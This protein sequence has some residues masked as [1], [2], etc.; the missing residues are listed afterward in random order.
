MKWLFRHSD[1]DCCC[2][3]MVRWR[4]RSVSQRLCVSLVTLVW[5]LER[6]GICSNWRFLWR[7]AWKVIVTAYLC[8]A[9]SHQM[10]RLTRWRR[11]RDGRPVEKWPRCNAGL[12]SS[13]CRGC[14]WNPNMN[15]TFRCAAVSG[16]LGQSAACYFWMWLTDDNGGWIIAPLVWCHALV[17]C[18]APRICWGKKGGSKVN[19]L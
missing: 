10:L 3:N 14:V 17:W 11:T 8:S 4:R 6:P 1:A 18:A 16:L 19:K 7:A 15:S 13:I 12:R 2:G 5:R 9:G